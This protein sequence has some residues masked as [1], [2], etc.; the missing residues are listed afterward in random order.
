MDLVR[1]LESIG[2]YAEAVVRL[3]ASNLRHVHNADG[4][5]VQV[6]WLWSGVG[7]SSAVELGTRLDRRPSQQSYLGISL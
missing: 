4:E 7:F 1:P 5:V 2:Y 3:L 6:M